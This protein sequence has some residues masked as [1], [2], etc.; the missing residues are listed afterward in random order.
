MEQASRSIEVAAVVGADTPLGRGVALGLAARGMAVVVS[1]VDE[2]AI[3]RVVGEIVVGGSAARH[4]PGKPSD[5]RVLEA[6]VVKAMESFGALTLLVTVAMQV[7]ERKAFLEIA[8]RRGGA[9]P[10]VLHIV[11]NGGASPGNQLVIAFEPSS[12]PER[13]LDLALYL[14]S[15]AAGSIQDQRVF[16]MA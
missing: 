13:A 5:S 10:R 14:A 9:R 6:I 11:G 8:A 3:G 12:D 7:D 1:G 15:R 2:R 4:V 16:V